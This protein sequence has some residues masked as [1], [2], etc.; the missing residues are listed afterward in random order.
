[1]PKKTYTKEFKTDAVSLVTE[2]SYS[3]AEA[4]R[5]LDI[6]E[7]MLGKW[8]R[9]A[10]DDGSDAFRGRGN[11]TVEKKEISQLKEE[12]RR[13]KMEKEILKKATVFFA[14]ETR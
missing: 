14:K 7:S 9:S 5:R 4:A 2:Q 10:K 11:I 8:V 13:L 12:V 1:M 6:N 3:V